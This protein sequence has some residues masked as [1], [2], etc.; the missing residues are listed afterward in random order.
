M[1]LS[2]IAALSIN[3][4]IGSKGKLPWHLPEDLKFF[5]EKTWNKILIMGRKTLDSFPCGALPHRMHI[6]LTKNPK[7][8]KNEKAPIYFVS[9]IKEALKK[10]ESEINTED[11]EEVFI[12]GGS[13]IFSQ[14]MDF[15]QYAYLT[16]IHKEY[17]GDTFYPQTP[18]K[19]LSL[20]GFTLIERK[21][22]EGSPTFSFLT[23]KK[24]RDKGRG[25]STDIMVPD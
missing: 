14:S 9:N 7:K 12:I 23:Y 8:T 20:R 10:A 2:H 24:K 21:D 11:K 15:I 17:S 25:Y 3:G 16:L 18:E 19:N 22:K 5:K 1:I 4:V 6:V 13:Q